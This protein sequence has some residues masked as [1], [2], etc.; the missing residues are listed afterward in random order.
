MW[1]TRRQRRGP[2]AADGDRL[3]RSMLRTRSTSIMHSNPTS[4]RVFTSLL[5]RNT[6]SADSLLVGPTQLSKRLGMRLTTFMDQLRLI[7]RRGHSRRF[8]NPM[9]RRSYQVTLTA[10][11][12]NAHREANRRFELARRAFMAELAGSE[13]A[14]A[15]TLWA[16]R[17]AADAAR[18]GATSSVPDAVSGGPGSEAAQTRALP[19]RRSTTPI[20]RPARTIG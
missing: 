16:M 9:D 5:G 15:K 7:E 8:D 17:I 20:P 1:V 10:A 6:F 2:C 13:A 3:L 18:S 12:L 4:N 11:G 19:R 14:A